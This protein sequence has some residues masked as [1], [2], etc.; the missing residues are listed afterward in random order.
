MKTFKFF[1]TTHKFFLTFYTVLFDMNHIYASI[2][3]LV[4]I[5][6]IKKVVKE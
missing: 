4:A 1:G 6:I 5:E 3:C 2:L